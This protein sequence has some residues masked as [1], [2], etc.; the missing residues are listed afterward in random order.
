MQIAH[1]WDCANFSIL[2]FFLC[3]SQPN[4]NF[5]DKFA[6][7]MASIVEHYCR[8]HLD[9]KIEKTKF[10]DGSTSAVLLLW[11]WIVKKND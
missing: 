10:S 6:E 4:S 8:K 5:L 11:M 7:I 1:F 9:E 2:C 3:F